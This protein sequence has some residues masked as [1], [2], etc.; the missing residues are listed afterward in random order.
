MKFIIFATLDFTHKYEL[1]SYISLYMFINALGFYIPTQRIHNDYFFNV[2]G[3]SSEWIYQRTGILTRSKAAEGENTNTMGIAAV[4]Q[5]L[6]A[7]PYPVEDVDLIIGASYSPYDTVATL[8]HVIQREF[9]IRHTRAVYVSSACSSFLNALEIVEGYFAGG[10]AAKALIVCSE[11]NTAYSHDSDPKAGHLWGDAAVAMF[12]SKDK[13]METEAEITNIYTRALGHI[14]KGPAGVFLRPKTDG[15]Q[16]PDG[17]DVF[18]YA[19]KYMCEAIEHILQQQSYTIDDISYIIA[20]QA[21]M[22]IINNIAKQLQL[23]DERFL[24]NIEELGN[25]GSPSS[26]LVLAQHYNK[27]K[28]GDKIILTVFGGGYSNG[29]CLICF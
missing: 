13:Q 18:M 14:G 19:C 28:R 8:A 11:H 27:F 26:P 15:I 23:P 20:H 16:M 7:L 25:T 6:P 4:K 9:D 3:L 24:S 5:A 21:N 17:R 1:S 12:I 10:K 29:S 2:N 22:R